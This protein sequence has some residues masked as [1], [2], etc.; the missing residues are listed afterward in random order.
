MYLG[1]GADGCVHPTF[2]LWPHFWPFSLL[3]R[4]CVIVSGVDT[5]LLLR[6]TCILPLWFSLYIVQL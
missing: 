5:V 3:P 2:W 4:P 1:M 6:A